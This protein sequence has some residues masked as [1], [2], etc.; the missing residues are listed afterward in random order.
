MYLPK[1]KYITKYSTGNEFI[2]PDG[3]Y[4]IGAYVETYKG[5]FYEGKEFNSD[6]KKLIDTRSSKEFKQNVGSFKNSNVKPTDKDYK[7]G[8]FTRYIVQDKRNKEIIEV[9]E[10]KFAN[11]SRQNYIRSVKLEWILSQP[12]ED[13]NEGP[14]IY[15]GARTQNKESVD[16]AEKVIKGISQFIFNYG[17]FV[18]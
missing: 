4:Y 18:V 11:L 6:S 3:S 5:N 8:I 10:D 12:L 17:Q 1:S 14:Y 16:K 13:L 15:F 2:K 7:K 9:T